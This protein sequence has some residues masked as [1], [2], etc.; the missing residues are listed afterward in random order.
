MASEQLPGWEARV[1][2]VMHTPP[3]F[4]GV[5]MEFFVANALVS[6]FCAMVWWPTL[7]LGAGL[8]GI[9]YVGTKVEPRWMPLLWAYWTYSHE[10]E[11]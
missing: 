8:Y 4:G 3:T 11:G 9:V 1:F 5:P 6:L 7:L 2:T 10:Y